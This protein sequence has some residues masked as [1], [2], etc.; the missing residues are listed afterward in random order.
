MDSHG[1]WH[2]DI[3]EPKRTCPLPMI[4]S[5]SPLLLAAVGVLLAAVQPASAWL[6]PV[7]TKGNKLFS[8][9]TGLEFR[10]KG[11]AY[12]PTPNSGN[13][14][15]VKNYDW[16]ADEHEDIWTPHLAVLKDLGVNAI[17]LYSVDPSKAHDKFMC[18]CS[19]A[20]IYVLV[21]MGAPYVKQP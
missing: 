14:S 18:A 10:I 3:R 2:S 9:D 19:E 17:R 15:T 8:S 16:A 7:V 11:M 20:G 12:S 13:M 6:A 21:G 1:L 4:L 5:R